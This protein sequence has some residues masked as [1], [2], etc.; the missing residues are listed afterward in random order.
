M[1]HSTTTYVVD[2]IDAIYF[3]VVGGI[4]MTYIYHPQEQSSGDDAFCYPCGSDRWYSVSHLSSVSLA[5]KNERS[6]RAVKPTFHEEKEHF[7]EGL[8]PMMVRIVLDSAEASVVTLS[9]SAVS[10]L[11]ERFE[12]RF[13]E[14]LHPHENKNAHANVFTGLITD[15]KDF[16]SDEQNNKSISIISSP[17]VKRDEDGD[18]DIFLA[19]WIQTIGDMG[20]RKSHSSRA[21]EDNI[22]ENLVSLVYAD[23]K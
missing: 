9:V 2:L 10:C 13:L 6:N 19:T 1:S 3:L 5:K 4:G 14:S 20:Y 8:H 21:S 7:S 18:V 11:K 23:E 16:S 12:Q 22:Q 15:G 17:F